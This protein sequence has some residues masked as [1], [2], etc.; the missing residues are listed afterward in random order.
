MLKRIIAALLVLMLAAFTLAENGQVNWTEAGLTRTLDGGSVTLYGTDEARIMG[1]ADAVYVSSPGATLELTGSVLHGGIYCAGA[2]VSAV[3]NVNAEAVTDGLGWGIYASGA[4]LSVTGSVKSAGI[5]VY[6]DNSSVS[7]T[8]SV[9]AESAESEDYFG[10]SWGVS[11]LNSSV[12][13]TGDIFAKYVGVN[14]DASEV[15]TVG[16]ISV[17]GDGESWGINAQ[18][19]SSVSSVG[20]ISATEVG[21]RAIA[22]SVSVSG[23]IELSETLTGELAKN[24]CAIDAEDGASVSA[25]GNVTA[26]GTGVYASGSKVSVTGDV[27]AI[28]NDAQWSMGAEANNG[29]DVSING[30][31]SAKYAGVFAIGSQI[32]VGGSVSA[33]GDINGEGWGASVLD[34]GKITVL[35][36]VNAVCGIHC[37]G[38]DN[39]VIVLGSVNGDYALAV[40]NG[41]SGIVLVKELNGALGIEKDDAIKPAEGEDESALTDMIY[42]IADLHLNGAEITGTTLLTID[43]TEYIA[44]REGDV[45]TVTGQGIQT[46]SAGKYATVEQTSAESYKITVA[47]GGDLSITVI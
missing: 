30:N 3:G 31:V 38:G 41:A 37:E 42:Y 19:G 17:L 9:L 27:S 16:D 14:A 24:C 45:L 46:V 26:V 4:N 35:G 43:G 5:A 47:R 7:V 18:N 39:T 32:K 44:A 6:A 28:E 29:A 34:G 36:D 33:A 10:K 11:C 23:N 12:S 25:V 8:G 13:V 22:S 15:R 20:D 40:H 1:N 2:S 21:V